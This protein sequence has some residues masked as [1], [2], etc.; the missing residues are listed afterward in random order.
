MN[1][2]TLIYKKMRR[3]VATVNLEFHEAARMREE[4]IFILLHPFH[5]FV[6]S[7]SLVEKRNY[8]TL[9]HE[10]MRRVMITVNLKFQVTIPIHE[11]ETFILLHPFHHFVYRNEKEKQFDIVI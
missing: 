10:K 9:L 8:M 11:E 7:K 5:H 6:Y 4:E 1:H 2:M 3:V